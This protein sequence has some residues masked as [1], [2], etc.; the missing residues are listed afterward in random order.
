MGR[1]ARGVLLEEVAE[2][3]PQETVRIL[4]GSFKPKGS[5]SGGER[6]SLCVLKFKGELIVFASNKGFVTMI[7]DTMDWDLKIATLL[8]DYAYKKL[9]KDITEVTFGQNSYSGCQIHK[10][11]NSPMMFLTWSLSY[12]V[13][14]SHSTVL[15]GCCPGTK[16][17][18]SCSQSGTV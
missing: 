7:L 1:K 13:W 8:E 17:V 16:C 10:A 3:A 4:K 15:A 2:E 18:A 9:N 5:L 6:K 12:T 11:L 14:G